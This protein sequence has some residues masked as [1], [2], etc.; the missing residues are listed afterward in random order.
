MALH[1]ILSLLRTQETQ[2][3]YLIVQVSGFLVQE[4]LNSTNKC[5]K[6]Y[7]IPR[8]ISKGDLK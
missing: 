6:S 7:S 3:P 5:G 1:S 8:H 2:V 4:F